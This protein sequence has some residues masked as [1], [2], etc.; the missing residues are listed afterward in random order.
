MKKT[1]KISL[2]GIA[3]NIEEDAYA[4]LN[5]YLTSLKN[6]LGDSQEANEIYGD[7]EERAADLFTEKLGSREIVDIDM[8]NGVIEIL[9]RPEQI[10][11]EED[12][13]ATKHKANRQDVRKR[14]Y[15]DDENAVIGGVC[16]GLAAYFNIDP[17]VFRILFVVLA[18]AKGF[19]VVV[20]IILWA[21]IPRAQTTRQRMEM[22]GED[23]NL[24]NLEKNIKKEYEEVKKSMKKHRVSDIFESIFSA[25]GKFF[26]VIGTILG[27]LAKIVVVILAIAFVSIGLVGL[28][29]SIASVFLGGFI[30]SLFPEFSGFTINEVL[31]TTV[32]LGS[33]LWV[34]I[35]VFF[36]VAI[37]LIALIYLGLRMVFR[38]KP[39]DS[40]FF[41][42][43]ATLWI[44][45]V[46]ILAFVFF[47]QA[48]S[49][50]ILET[51][52]E[53]VSL[54][55][56]EENF[57]RLYLY[58]DEEVL[59]DVDYRDD[60][61]LFDEYT[62]ADINGVPQVIGQPEIFIGKSNSSNFE[63]TIE[64]KSRGATRLLARRSANNI[65]Y[66]FKF[67]DSNLIINPHYIV[68]NGEKWRAQ[69]VDITIHVPE[70]KSIYIDKGLQEMLSYEQEYCFC[71]PDEM[72]A[73]TWIM[74]DDRLEPLGE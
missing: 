72:V 39:R 19:G 27:V 8:V 38:F 25:F 14:F 74:R 9:G 59:E 5:E 20:Y 21:L 13:D 54:Q 67:V 36:V 47:L 50:T 26:A 46:T 29:S 18:F 55:K 65:R 45:A 61:V 60:I 66:D 15:R 37:P 24:S 3:F 57:Y 7:I 16:S 12:E 56:Q 28:L 32:D 44:V 40:V 31:A 68:S 6:H 33:M 49:F 58:I 51:V 4:A 30:T 70:G 63:L 41:V 2:G 53:E 43:G 34:T 35:P 22:R 69:D 23:V 17:L 71:W 64:K 48:R 52:K 62:I 73:R 11:D 10:T 42:T 1:V